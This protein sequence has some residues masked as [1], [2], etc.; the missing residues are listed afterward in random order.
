MR[1]AFG[2]GISWEYT[3]QDGYPA[4]KIKLANREQLIRDE[5]PSAGAPVLISTDFGD[6]RV[7]V[8]TEPLLGAKLIHR[9]MQAVLFRYL[10]DAIGLP[11]ASSDRHR[12]EMVMREDK[13]G[14]RYLFIVNP[15]LHQRIE[16]MVTV[17]GEYQQVTDLGISSICSVPL[18]PRKP[19]VVKRKYDALGHPVGD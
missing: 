13:N 17:K 15:D 6:G 7:V 14:R 1:Q 16:D 18:A 19:V 11:A 10:H 4:W 9:Q 8:S 3:G 12:F 5:L 2:D